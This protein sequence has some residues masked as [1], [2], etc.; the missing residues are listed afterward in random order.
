MNDRAHRTLV[1][2]VDSSTQS[3]KVVLV[4]AD[5]GE[6]VETG[7]APHPE[8][9]EVDPEAWW[10]AL[11]QAGAGLLDRA[12]AIAV[13]GQQHGMVVLDDDGVVIRPA[14]LWNDLR[15]ASNADQLVDELG[16]PE[17]AMA[18]VGSVIPAS[19]T[20]AKLRWLAEHE[21]EAAER[22]AAVALPHDWLTARL[23]ASGDVLSALATDAGDASGTGY[24]DPVRRVW[25]PA[26]LRR[27]L[28]HD[29]A[30]PRLAAPNETVGTTAWGARLGPGTGDNMAAALGLD[31][32]PGDVA[33]SIGTSGTAFA[34]SDAPA[35]RVGPEVCGFCDATGRHLPLVCT[36]NASRILSM[37]AGLLGTSFDAFDELALAV[38][39]GHGGLTFL[40]YLDGERTPNRPEATG[41][42]TGL[43]SSTTRPELARAAVDALLCSLADAVDALGVTPQRVVLIG[44]GARSQAVQAAAPAF[45]GTDV[46]IP[47]PAEYVALGAARQAAWVLSGS[48][49]A[50]AWPHSAEVVTADDEDRS[51]AA[52]VR[53][54]YAR[55]R[56]TA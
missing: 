25:L 44:G 3:T 53:S 46:T 18:T 20:S 14:L 56:D 55:L 1:V 29:A 5:T 16:G 9:T 28:G 50:P 47:E 33:V 12:E 24:F 42:I 22:V 32:G 41:I 40:P 31:L 45:F 37:T 13:A 2:G 48:A 38:P 15:A 7:S 11:Q 35:I 4:D 51:L 23:D 10:T 36:I 19:F 17:A 43:T 52:S 39:I 27:A 6:I 49:D 34:V 21:P 30:T 26:E 8:G 54:R